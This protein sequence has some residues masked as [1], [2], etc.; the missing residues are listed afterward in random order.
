MVAILQKLLAQEPALGQHLWATLLAAYFKSAKAT[1]RPLIPTPPNPTIGTSSADE[2]SIQ[3]PAVEAAYRWLRQRNLITPKQ[4]KRL[5][6]AAKKAAFTV[7]GSATQDAVTRIRDL[8]ADDVI[9]GGT[10]REFQAAATEALDSSALSKPRLE[11]LYRTHV[12]QATAAG[13]RAIHEHPLIVDEFPYRLWTATHDSRTRHEHLAMET[14]GQNG[15]A[16]YRS[17]D[18]MWE[19][20]YPPAGWNCR[21]DVIALSVEDAAR[22]GSREAQKWLKTGK[23]PASPE[24]AKKPYPIQ[25][26]K[27]WPG[28]NGIR[29]A[30]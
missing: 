15:T 23:K 10:L 13:Q 21:C 18:P 29:A 2:P 25:L 1:A 24:Y 22:H 3:Y 27:G 6:E 26:P 19:T 28:T 12:G 8:L 16:V 20:L 7:A 5:D 30:V 14:H 9:Q 17:D 4:Y 11:T